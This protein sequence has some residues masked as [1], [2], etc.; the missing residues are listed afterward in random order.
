MSDYQLMVIGAG[1]AGYEAALRAAKHGLKTA[2]VEQR[3]LGGTC[4]NRGCVPTKAL[5]HASGLYHSVTEAE[6][7]GVRVEN[8]TLDASKLYA[9]KDEVVEKLRSGIEQ[10]LKK[11]KVDVL[12]GHGSIE[13]LGCVRVTDAEGTV[14]SYTAD[15]ILLATGAV[16]SKPPIPGLE[17]EGVVT[18]D[19][20]LSGSIP[21]PDS[22]VIIGGGVIGVEFATFYSDL[23]RSVTIVEGLD[24]LLPNMD[25]ELG[26]SLAMSLKKKG[27]TVVTNAF[28]EGV[29]RTDEGLTVTFSAKNGK[30]QASGALVL[31]AIGR[32]PNADGV[33][34]GAL[35][36]KRN[37]KALWVDETYQTS[38]SGIYAVGDVSSRVQLA[39]VA[40]AQAIACVDLLCGKENDTKQSVIPSCV[41]VR[42]EIASV[43]LT[44]AEAK[45]QGIPVKVGKC[46]LFGNA[47][48]VI[49]DAGRSFMKVVGHAETGEI[50]GA[51]LLCESAT[52]L[53]GELGQ[54]V[55]N[56]WTAKQL[57]C[58]MR[59]HPTFAEAL[60]EA[61]RDLT[62]KLGA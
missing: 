28:V 4:L 62:D 10:L 44:E 40:T 41:Y 50:L 45:E 46:V 11:A 53:I 15:S 38:L 30:G 6:E 27:V 7:F 35:E 25:R 49:S 47:R 3:E 33:F 36:P 48:T 12:T 57:L 20:L 26:Q 37:G 24:R 23:N 22:I 43:G 9:H 52:D 8:A 5:L 14:K 1:P 34:T 55:A 16:P 31:C 60:T 21:I 58:A 32:T 54:A 2:V 59:P 17:Q 61:L 18:S 29:E 51:Q 13:T 42:P 19:E 56:R 39:H